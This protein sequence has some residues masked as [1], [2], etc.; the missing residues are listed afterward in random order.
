MGIEWDMQP[1]IS[2][3]VCSKMWDLLAID[4]NLDR[5]DDDKPMDLGDTVVSDNPK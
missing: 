4:G 2:K 5:E 3:W 1:I